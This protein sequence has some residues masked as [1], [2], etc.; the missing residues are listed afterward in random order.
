MD[1]LIHPTDPEVQD[2]VRLFFALW[3][4]DPTRRALQSLQQAISGRRSLPENLHLTLAFLGS[5]ARSRVEELQ[6]VLNAMPPFASTLMIDVLGYFRGAR[7]AWAGMAQPDPALMQWQGLLRAALVERQILGPRLET[8]N[9]H[10]TLA[11]DAEKPTHSV[12]ATPVVWKAD[13]IVLVESQGGNGSPTVYR[14]VGESAHA[15]QA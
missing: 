1:D 8:F 12:L 11:R 3:P 6:D 7:I 2:R 13:R 4:D 10:I 9:P 5:Q 15:R 14:I